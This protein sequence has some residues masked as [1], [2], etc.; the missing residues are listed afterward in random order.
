MS[1]DEVSRRDNGKRARGGHLMKEV[2]SD[3]ETGGNGRK[4][5]AVGKGVRQEVESVRRR[6]ENLHRLD[7]GW[8]EERGE[9]G[10]D[11]VVMQMETA[12]S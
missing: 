7:L 3:P 8:M 11:E 12:L 5:I 9:R 2:T 1:V 4:G 10:R 6:K